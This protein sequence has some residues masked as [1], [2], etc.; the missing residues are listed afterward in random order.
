MPSGVG[1]R[2]G[3]SRNQFFDSLAFWGGKV[4]CR[5]KRVERQWRL[6]LSIREGWLGMQAAR[7]LIAVINPAATAIAADGQE[8]TRLT[9]TVGNECP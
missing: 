1:V 4:G 5:P 6:L 8:R 2:I 7:S 3:I 9:A